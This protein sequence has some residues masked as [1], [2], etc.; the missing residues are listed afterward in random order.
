MCNFNVEF[1][2]Q[3]DIFKLEV[4]MC[5]TFG[6]KILR[7]QQKL[8]EVE[9]ADRLWECT[10]GNKVEKLASLDKLKHHVGNRDLRTVLFHF[11]STFSII[12]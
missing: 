3:Q 12:K 8:F 11:Y 6:V 4:S 7:N 2:V 10:L 5:D 1:A 9:T